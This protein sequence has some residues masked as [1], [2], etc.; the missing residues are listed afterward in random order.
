MEEDIKSYSP[1]VMFRGIPC[2]RNSTY[3]CSFQKL[4]NQ[5]IFNEKHNNNILHAIDETKECKEMK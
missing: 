4:F 2:I 3:F 5:T 1:T